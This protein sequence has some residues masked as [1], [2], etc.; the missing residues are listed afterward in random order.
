MKKLLVAVLLA[1]LP[2]MAMALETLTS[3]QDLV[4]KT[5][6]AGLSATVFTEPAQDQ[7]WAQYKANIEAYEKK[8]KDVKF[9]LAPLSNPEFAQM[10]MLLGIQ[11]LPTTLF[12][13]NGE[14]LTGGAGAPAT[15]EQ[16]EAAIANIQKAVAAMRE[17]Q[18]LEQKKQQEEIPAAPQKR[19]EEGTIDYRPRQGLPHKVMNA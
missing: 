9:F 8:H 19:Q 4:D 11:A 3:V 13:E 2:Q 12:S 7:S 1:L 10:A 17:Q 16:L 18:K 14:V 15:A 6:G 5:A